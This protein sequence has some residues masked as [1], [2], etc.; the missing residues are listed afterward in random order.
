MLNPF[1]V[2]AHRGAS[3][4]AP[5]NTLAAFEQ[6]WQ[7]GARQFE[8]DVEATADGCVVVIHDTLLD[9]T[10]NGFGPV[11]ARTW[12]QLAGLDAGAWFGPAFAGARIPRLDDVLEQ[13]EGRARLHIEIKGQASE[14]VQRTVALVRAHGMQ[15]EVVMTSFR[16][17]RLAAIREQAPEL[18]TGWLVPAATDET[19]TRAQALGITQ[20]CPRATAVT[21]EVVARLHA[22]G[23]VVRAWGVETDA[24]MLAVV[25]AGADGM[26]VNAP[27]R[28]ITH[29]EQQGRAWA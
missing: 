2:I 3:A 27:D 29:L 15:R 18:A 17:A 19:I 10:T 4:H 11:A 6:A 1:M 13:F 26:T 5:E 20:F 8:L 21:P 22:L 23:F 9:R 24:Q 25:A 12:E 14:L 28:L 7:L 16:D